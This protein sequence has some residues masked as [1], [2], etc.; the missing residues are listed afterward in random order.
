[1]KVDIPKIIHFV[2]VGGG[3]SRVQRWRLQSWANSNPH[4]KINLWYDSESLLTNA[5]RMELKRDWGLTYGLFAS[6]QQLRDI[7][8]AAAREIR[9][10]G[11][12]DAARRSYL[13]NRLG[14]STA[15]IDSMIEDI[16][17]SLVFNVPNGVTLCDVRNL[18]AGGMENINLYETELYRRG[19]NMGAA[20]DIL[21]IE[22]IIKYGGIYMDIDLG[23]R[24]PFATFKVTKDLALFGRYNEFDDTTDMSHK[25]CNALMASHAGSQ[26]LIDCRND[27]KS[28]YKNWF[29]NSDSIVRYYENL[30]SSTIELTGPSLVSRQV[31]AAA[32]KSSTS[33]SGVKSDGTEKSPLKYE[34]WKLQELS[35]LNQYIIWKTDESLTHDWL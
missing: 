13:V 25:F 20:S 30:R 28:G 10:G 14:K 21:R 34:N 24:Q 16:R 9:A 8:E 35:F 4:Y 22:L 1:M 3:I 2:W 27:I 26:M 32:Q 18:M 6:D 11:G 23:C 15:E 33:K 5:V 7:Q 31:K 19:G 17:D 29:S 12:K